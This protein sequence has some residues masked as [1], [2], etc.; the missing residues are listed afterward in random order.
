[1]L[2]GEAQDLL[3]TIKANAHYRPAVA[4][5][6]DPVTFVH[7]ID[8]P[9][10]MACQWEDE[11]TGGHCPTLAAHMTGTTQKWFTFT[12]GAHIDSL[13]PATYNRWYDFLELYVADQAPSRTARRW[14]A[15]P[16]RWSTRR[17]WAPRRTTSSRCRRT[18]SS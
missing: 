17:R 16:L 9:V 15:T 5:P 4:D 10:F 7:K 8:V 3:Q 11:Q 18:R 2:H 12:N 6:L 1:M 14:S 13:D